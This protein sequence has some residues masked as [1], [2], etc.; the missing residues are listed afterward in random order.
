MTC[1]IL[2]NYMIHSRLY[3]REELNY[4]DRDAIH[5]YMWLR[6]VITEVPF[7]SCIGLVANNI[8]QSQLSY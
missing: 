4:V 5:S 1:G 6:E 8:G 3:V 7:C 2:H